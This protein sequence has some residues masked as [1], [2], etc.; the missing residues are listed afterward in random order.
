MLKFRHKTDDDERIGNK[1]AK[2]TSSYK[3]SRSEAN[4][5]RP[6]ECNGSKQGSK[7]K[8]SYIS[9]C[10]ATPFI[11]SNPR[12]QTA[13]CF[14]R[15]AR[16]LSLFLEKYSAPIALSFGEA[17]T[18]KGQLGA[19]AA[20]FCAFSTSILYQSE[21]MSTPCLE[22]K[23]I[24]LT[25]IGS[26]AYPSESHRVKGHSHIPLRSGLDMS[27]FMNSSGDRPGRF[28][29]SG[30]HP[31][32]GGSRVGGV[33]NVAADNDDRTTTPCGAVVNATL[34]AGNKTKESAEKESFMVVCSKSIR[35]EKETTTLLS[36]PK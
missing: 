24:Y 5:R 17:R 1:T 36:R 7:P 28:S 23:S 13:P 26:T 14:K 18:S 2:L 27:L 21:N 10:P 9:R 33:S 8:A 20:S 6:D 31:A 35:Y 29:H 11:K 34:A 19:L 32:P 3:A 12:N 15:S 25:Y 30:T 4:F 22:T 16:I